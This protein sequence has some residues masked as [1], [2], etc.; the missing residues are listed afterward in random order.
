MR[1]RGKREKVSGGGQLRC[2]RNLLGKM[3]SSEKE[4][5][6]INRKKPSMHDRNNCL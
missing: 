5:W 6:L 4:A 2:T 1:R 3:K